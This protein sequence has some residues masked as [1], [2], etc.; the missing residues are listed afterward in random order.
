[1]P[2]RTCRKGLHQYDA[3]RRR[4]PHCARAAIARYLDS[5]KGRAAVARYR[6]GKKWEAAVQG[7][8]A[9]AKDR[10]AQKRTEKQQ[11]SGVLPG[12]RLCRNGLHQYP[13]D[14]PKVNGTDRCLECHRAQRARYRSS[15]VGRAA[16]VRNRLTDAARAARARYRRSAKGRAAATRYRLKRRTRRPS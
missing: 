16:R 10:A 9:R 5:E 13:V 15:P 3:E 14:A 11:E 7:Q 1:V 12:M 8:R 2:L 6:K 4:C